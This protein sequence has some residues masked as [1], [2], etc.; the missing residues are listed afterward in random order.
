[1]WVCVAAIPLLFA[2]EAAQEK[3][4]DSKLLFYVGACIW[5]ICLLGALYFKVIQ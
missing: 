3:N 5:Q 2:R 1:M 4:I